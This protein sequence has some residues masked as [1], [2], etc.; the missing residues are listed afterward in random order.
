MPVSGKEREGKVLARREDPSDESPAVGRAVRWGSPSSLLNSLAHLLIPKCKAWLPHPLPKCV[1]GMSAWGEGKPLGSI[2]FFPSWWG[3]QSQNGSLMTFTTEEVPG[4]ET[5]GQTHPIA[6]SLLPPSSLPTL[7][8]SQAETVWLWGIMKTKMWIVFCCS[9][10]FLTSKPE[11]KNTLSLK[12]VIREE[13][14]KNPKGKI[15]TQHQLWICYQ[16]KNYGRDF[17]VQRTHI[18]TI[19]FRSWNLSSKIIYYKNVYKIAAH[20]EKHYS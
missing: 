5:L 9:Y 16:E 17:P 8:G 13:K 18:A 19:Y 11:V 10:W 14:K 15:K 1:C 20:C 4:C 6:H 12:N 3:D 2:V 7:M